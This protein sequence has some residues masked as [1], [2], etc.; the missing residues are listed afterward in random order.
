MARRRQRSEKLIDGDEQVTPGMLL[1][2]IPHLHYPITVTGLLLKPGD[3]VTKNTPVFNYTYKSTVQEYDTYGEATNVEKTF[4]T[5]YESQVEGEVLRWKIHKGMIISGPG[6]DLVEITE[7]CQHNV[8][9]G[10]MCAECGKDMT[11]ID[12]GTTTPDHLRAN[13]S[14]A[15]SKPGLKV[16]TEEANR[17][18]TLSKKRLIESKKLSLVVDLDQTI[19]HATV[20]PTV[21]EWMDDVDNPNYDAVKDVQKF[22]LDEEGPPHNCWYYVKK[23]PGLTNFLTNISKLYELHIYTMGTRAYARNVAK[24]VDPEKKI[25]SDRIL[26]RDENGSLTAK[27]LQKIFPVDARMV[28]I[29]D[30]RGD[31]WDWSKSLIKVVPYDFFKGIGDIN[32][33]FLPKRQDIV[34][35]PQQQPTPP[36]STPESQPESNEIPDTQQDKPPATDG[37][38][39]PDKAGPESA[40]EPEASTIDKLVSMGGPTDATTMQEKVIE[41]DEELASQIADRPLLQKQLE[42]EQDEEKAESEKA[43]S[44]KAESEPNGVGQNGHGLSDNE[45]EEVSVSHKPRHNLLKDDDIELDNLERALRAVHDKFYAVHKKAIEAAKKAMG[46]GRVSELKGERSPKKRPDLDN[47][48]LVPDV[49]TIMPDMKAQVLGGCNIVFSGVIPLSSRPEA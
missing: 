19:I 10:G 42:L 11:E 38:A 47:M 44:E 46:G 25:F 1:R 7:P 23:R 2:S 45:D 15:H 13:V 49:Q 9:F 36:E 16:S 33:S 6:V 29:I 28:L 27:S 20:D 43:E 18:E 41:Q 31:V 17:T 39:E 21:G 37:D 40:S 8:Q 5:R 22:Q 14:V 35:E 24:I 3:K 26:S 12:Y 4:P 32:S 48:S 30:D 34:P